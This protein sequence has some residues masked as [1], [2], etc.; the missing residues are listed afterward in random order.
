MNRLGFGCFRIW[1][2][3]VWHDWWDSHPA[4]RQVRLRGV[5]LAGCQLPKADLSAADCTGANLSRA[6]L[7]GEFVCLRGEIGL[8]KAC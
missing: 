2:G 7:T 3:R 6:N 5:D 8:G 1:L 4:G